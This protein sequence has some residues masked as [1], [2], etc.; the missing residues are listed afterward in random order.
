MGQYLTQ[1]GLFY[2]RRDIG[3]W[4]GSLPALGANRDGS[5]HGF[6]QESSI[7][8]FHG[9]LPALTNGVSMFLGSD[10]GSFETDIPQTCQDA[11]IMFKNCTK[12]TTFTG[13]L[14]SNRLQ[15]QNMFEGCTSLK[16]LWPEYAGQNFP[17]NLRNVNYMFQN[18]TSLESFPFTLGSAYGTCTSMFQGCS[19]L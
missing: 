6:F 12:L 15:C 19:K 10:L 13:E 17:W 14:H 9:E 4:Y 2:Q 1:G 3:E 5:Y 7:T 8:G 16:T 18:C 11:Q